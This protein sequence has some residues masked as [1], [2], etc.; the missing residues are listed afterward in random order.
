M[1]GLVEDDYEARKLHVPTVYV[2][3]DSTLDQAILINGAENK[4]VQLHEYLL[5]YTDAFD[6]Y[7]YD[8]R[9]EYVADC[10][11]L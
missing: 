5:L 6:T 2:H 11:A 7:S 3:E 4:Y 8:I 10:I 9:I 1:V